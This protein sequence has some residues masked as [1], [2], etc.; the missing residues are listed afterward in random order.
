MNYPINGFCDENYSS[1]R[2]AFEKNFEEDL[3]LGASFTVCK[4]AKQLVDLWGGF[5]D[6]KKTSP[7]QKNTSVTVMSNTKIA[8]LIWVLSLVDRGRLTWT[9]R[10]R[11]TGL[12]SASG[13]RKSLLYGRF[14][15]IGPECQVSTVS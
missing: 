2:A 10:W 3:E 9:R 1:L 5:K 13:A 6:L 4:D 15:A 8:T 12:S 14:S 11:I 7:W